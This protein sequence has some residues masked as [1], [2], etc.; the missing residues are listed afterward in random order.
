[1]KQLFKHNE[2]YVLLIVIAFSAFIT[3]VNPVFLTVENLFDLLRSSS[4]TAILAVGVF[5]V[6]ISGG[7]DVSCTTIAI[8][9]QYI[10]V[11]VLIATGI[12]SILLAFLISVLIGITLGAINAVFVSLFKIPT[13][14]VTLGTSSLYHGLM[15][16]FVGTRAV[17][18]GGLPESIKAFG[19]MNV[20]TIPRGDGTEYGLSIFFLILIAVLLLSW[21]IMKYTMFGR[22]IYAIGG[23]F[24][25]AKRTGY[26][27]R[28]VQFFVY[29]YS[30]FLAGIMGVMHL[31]LIR[32]S[33]PNY[34]VGTELSIIAAVVLG[35]ARISGGTGTLTGTM[36]G[37]VLITIL[38]KNL[39]LLGL[40]SYWQKFFI[41]LVIVLGVTITYMQAKLSSKT[42]V[43]KKRGD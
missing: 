39:I 32:Y 21:F 22:G 13:L 33:N 20:L 19:R 10:S 25:A 29:M 37:V 40:S 38:E 17:N 16:E 23:N 27:T 11:N 24:E 15:L 43:T 35:G 34:L 36:I 1:M 42:V 31:A 26:N 12:D 3:A 4:G 5:M 9:G 6:L 30:G 7:I 28:K 8:V 2:T 41:G 14:I 18:V